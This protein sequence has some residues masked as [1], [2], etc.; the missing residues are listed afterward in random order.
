MKNYIIVVSKEA[1]NDLIDL[2]NVISFDYKSPLTSV[3]YINGLKKDISKLSRSAESFSIQT[4]KSLQQYGP[5][6]RRINYK[7]MA[8]VYNVINGVV[9][10]RRVIPSN[11]IA[12]L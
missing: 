5:A 2:S 8:I 11:S 10:I 4:R 1:T 7:K 12:G 9:Y 3:R 6:P